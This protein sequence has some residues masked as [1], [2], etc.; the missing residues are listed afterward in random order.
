MFVL[1]PVSDS[2]DTEM[3]FFA[4]FIIIPEVV[5][6]LDE[7]KILEIFIDEDESPLLV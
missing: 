4:G 6:Q 5:G 2:I 1:L 3:L 7:E